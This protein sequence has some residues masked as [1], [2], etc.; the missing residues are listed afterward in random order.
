MEEK[1]TSI[2]TSETTPEPSV[3]EKEGPKKQLEREKP[4]SKETASLQNKV[5][6]ALTAAF[7]SVREK[8]GQLRKIAEDKTYRKKVIRE[9]LKSVIKIGDESVDLQKAIPELTERLA[10]EGHFLFKNGLEVRAEDIDQNP[11]RVLV[12][13]RLA[14]LDLT[15]F[16]SLPTR[17]QKLYR[18]LL[19]LAHRGDAKATP[20]IERGIAMLNMYLKDESQGVKVAKAI[21]EKNQEI[22]AL[23]E[24]EEEQLQKA[25]SGEE[26]FLEAQLRYGKAGDG[27]LSVTDLKQLEKGE[28]SEETL[29]R[30]LEVGGK[31]EVAEIKKKIKSFVG[32]R[33]EKREFL[34][35]QIQDLKTLANSTKGE[36]RKKVLETIREVIY[37]K[38]KVFSAREIQNLFGISLIQ[39]ATEYAWGTLPQDVQTTPQRE[40]KLMDEGT[41]DFDALPDIVKRLVQGVNDTAKTPRGLTER[42][43][44][45]VV[46]RVDRI[47]ERGEIDRETQKK[48]KD[49]IGAKRK[50]IVIT[51]QKERQEQARRQYARRTGKS[52]EDIE[53]LEQLET[54]ED[55]IRQEVFKLNNEIGRRIAKPE[56]IQEGRRNR[57]VHDLV[58]QARMVG[59]ED[60]LTEL[61]ETIEAIDQQTLNRQDRELIETTKSL[62]ERKSD[63]LKIEKELGRA[64]PTS[65]YYERYYS[66]HPEIIRFFRETLSNPEEI[67]RIQTEGGFKHFENRVKRAFNILFEVVDSSTDQPFDSVFTSLYEMPVYNDIIRMLQQAERHIRPSNESLSGRLEGLRRKLTAERKLRRYTHNVAFILQTRGNLETLHKFAEDFVA[68]E[69]DFAFQNDPMVLQAVHFLE[70]KVNQKLAN[71]NWV[72]P[73]DFMQPIEGKIEIDEEVIKML[74]NYYKGLGV[75][76]EDWEIPRAYRIAKGISVGVTAIVL[77]RIA[78][79]DP[80][81]SGEMGRYKSYYGESLMSAWMGKPR[82]I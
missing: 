77:D 38:G 37:A 81:G 53:Q 1:H 70:Q 47:Y 14:S 21:R 78:E 26:P 75:E 79:A 34:S 28:V 10:K 71:N 33:G 22:V 41:G 16:D 27:R 76:L 45:G 61:K 44:E 72:V 57:T 31:L 64:Q 11:E 5:F 60:E 74:E 69:L 3:A 66:S 9:K 25:A 68:G 20:Y 6:A 55:N 15:S 58:V 12:L 43:L 59:D 82:Q 40:W 4:R 17:A 48:L 39:E 67:A 19:E 2:K 23:I 29:R 7:K 65:G 54:R 63:H 51:G 32:E 56:E 46:S 30:I 35:Q 18:Q 52:I 13:A 73:Q 62:L 8:P 50:E 80:P 42:Y 49:Q 36:A 24:R